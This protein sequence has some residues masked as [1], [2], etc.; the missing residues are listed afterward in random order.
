MSRTL[1]TDTSA[2]ETTAPRVGS[3]AHHSLHG[4]LRPGDQV[5]LRGGVDN[6]FDKDSP[7]HTD[8]VDQNTG[9]FTYDLPGRR[10]FVKA[11]Y[12]F[13]VPV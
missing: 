10:F 4:S 6:L 3:V 2:T 9:Q 12:K 1:A 13:Q 5:V 7:R 11:S 8:P